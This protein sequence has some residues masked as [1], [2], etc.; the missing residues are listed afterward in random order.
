MIALNPDVVRFEGLVWED[1]QLVAVDQLPH[2]LIEEFGDDGP[3]AAFVDVPERSVQV[4]VVRRVMRDEAGDP[5]LGTSGTLRFY[6]GPGASDA[7]RM[8]VDVLCVLTSVRSGSPEGGGGGAA[9]KTMN[10]VGVAS[11]GT[12]PITVVDATVRD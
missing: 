4:R 11:G 6:I 7:G 3:Y 2:K 12:N 8:R 10:F 1:V 9:T 5:P